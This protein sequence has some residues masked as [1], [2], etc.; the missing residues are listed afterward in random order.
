MGILSKAYRYIKLAKLM[1]IKNSYDILFHCLQI[2]KQPIRLMERTGH[3]N[4]LPKARMI[5]NSRIDKNTSSTLYENKWQ[6]II[7]DMRGD[8]SK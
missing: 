4:T 6:I 5:E 3:K 8:L 2:I 1:L 7:A